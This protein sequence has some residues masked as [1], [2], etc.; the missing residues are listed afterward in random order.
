MGW[1]SLCFFAFRLQG[2]FQQRIL[3]IYLTLG[4]GRVIFDYLE[5]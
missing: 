5:G 1:G 4:L 2:F 3:P